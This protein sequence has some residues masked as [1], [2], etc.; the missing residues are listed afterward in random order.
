MRGAVDECLA[1]ASA[2]QVRLPGNEW[3][4]VVRIMET[5]PDQRSSTAQDLAQGRCS[6]IDHLN[7][8]VV[9]RAAAHPEFRGRRQSSMRV[10]EN[11]DGSLT[12]WAK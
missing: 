11:E 12:G 4:T 5:M 3:E 7:G 8:Y 10:E 2:L 6:E 9:R 1:V